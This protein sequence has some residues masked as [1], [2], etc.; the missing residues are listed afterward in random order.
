[1]KKLVR[2][3]LL[4]FLGAWSSYGIATAQ[5]APPASSD[6]NKP[7][8]SSRPRTQ[9]FSG[10]ILSV[11]SKVKSITLQGANKPVVFITDKTRI[12]KARQAATFDVLTTNQAVTGFEQ[13][14]PSGKWIAQSLNVGDPRQI[15]DAPIGRTF[16]PSQP[17]TNTPPP[18]SGN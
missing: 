13:Q 2:T 1:M 18:R 5:T 3:A 12:I 9:R 16:V 6:T 15:P 14:D 10:T 11:D 17:R 7:A 8:A 4:I